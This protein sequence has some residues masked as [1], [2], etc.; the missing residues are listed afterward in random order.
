MENGRLWHQE[1]SDPLYDYTFAVRFE[2]PRELGVYNA[3]IAV[4]DQD[5]DVANDR[6]LNNRT[7]YFEVMDDDITAPSI[8]IERILGDGTGCKSW[9]LACHS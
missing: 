3:S 8:D 9:V 2:N 1:I 5:T 4:W 6:L 7:I